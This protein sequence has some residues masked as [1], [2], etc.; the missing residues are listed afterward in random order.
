MKTVRWYLRGGAD[1]LET[2]ADFDRL[3]SFSWLVRRLLEMACSREL[4]GFSGRAFD[5][6]ASLWLRLL[7]EER[8]QE[9]VETNMR[10]LLG[11]RYQDETEVVDDAGRS[12]PTVR[13][14]IDSY[15]G[16]TTLE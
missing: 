12:G 8:T 11:D 10:L 13:G 9:T 7:A 14:L 15:S 5:I 3:L 16:T 2:R 4:P 1:R 6:V